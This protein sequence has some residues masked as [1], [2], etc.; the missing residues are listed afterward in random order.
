MKSV[1][2]SDI[3]NRWEL[4][5]HFAL[6]HDFDIFT[7]FCL[8][9]VENRMDA[10]LHYKKRLI[11]WMSE[12]QIFPTI[13][14]RNITN[15]N[16]T[17]STKLFYSNMCNHQRFVFVVLYYHISIIRLC[18]SFSFHVKVYVRHQPS[19]QVPAIVAKIFSLI[20]LFTGRLVFM[21]IMCN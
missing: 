10:S 5:N 1:F 3:E 19:R 18:R 21:G 12:C 14:L 11:F 8:Q 9:V 6:W 7:L 13:K 16:P 2:V 4:G 20:K 15:K 17:N